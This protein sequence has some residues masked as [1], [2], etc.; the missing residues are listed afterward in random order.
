[1]KYQA[2]WVTPRN[3]LIP[4]TEHHI[5]L[6][7]DNPARFGLTRAYVIRLFRKHEEPLGFEGYAREIIMARVIRSGWIRLRYRP[8]LYSLIVQ[9]PD[10]RDKRS[11]ARALRVAR[12]VCSMDML[13]P[14]VSIAIM[15]LRKHD[16]E[17]LDPEQWQATARKSRK[18]GLTVRRRNEKRSV[19]ES[20]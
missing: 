3:R 7:C 20:V 15:G 2:Y 6:I 11:R 5:D 14:H 10:T 8:R 4:V 17:V 12:N 9:I 13:P 18:P 19:L 16:V 1:M